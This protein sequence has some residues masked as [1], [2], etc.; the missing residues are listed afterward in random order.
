MLAKD[1]RGLEAYLN[2]LGA[3]LWGRVCF[4]HP[5][6]RAFTVPIIKLDGR[7]GSNALAYSYYEKRIIRLSSKYALRNFTLYVNDVLPHEIMHQVDADLNGAYPESEGH[8][9]S[10]RSLMVQFR[11]EP[12]LEYKCL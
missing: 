12:L 1:K 11:F 2:A 7:L 5:K 6:L 3:Q 10:W 9:E 4:K 8:R